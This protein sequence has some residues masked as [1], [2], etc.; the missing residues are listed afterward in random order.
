MLIRIPGVNTTTKKNK[1]TGQVKRYYYHRRTG[2]RLPDDPTSME[3][4]VT[5]ARLDAQPIAEAPAERTF[6]HLVEEYKKSED[7]LELA[8]ST[9]SEYLRHIKYLEPVLGTFLV[10]GLRPSHVAKLKQKYAA[11]PT[12]AK[13][14]GRTISILLGYAAYPLE[15]I[16]TN[17]LVQPKRNAAKRRSKS[18]GQRPYEEAEIAMFRHKNPLG[19]RTRLAFEIALGTALRRE[20]LCKVPATALDG[21]T[22]AFVAGKNGE[23]LSL[24]VTEAMREANRAYQATR[25]AAGLPP[26]RFALSSES[27]SHLHKRTISAEIEAA[28]KA[29]GFASKQR[30]HALR[31]TAATR[32]FEVG[33]PYSTVQ[34][35]T[36]H[37]MAEMAKKYTDQ[38]RAAPLKAGIF[39]AADAAMWAN[40]SSATATSAST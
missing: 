40:R 25:A 37:R 11:T 26:S 21:E 2:E 23:L 35:L 9:K 30:L 28:C 7:F 22:F 34:E 10:R 15:W 16:P 3:F 32:L 38:K 4:L 20:D 29:A 5:K 24:P 8:P 14:I 39:N 12:L 19:T 6:K 36:G 18:V 27:G 33:V 17:P 31:F 1:R 13:A